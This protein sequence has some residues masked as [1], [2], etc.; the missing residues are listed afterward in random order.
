MV[1]E[2]SFVKFFLRKD[3]HIAK[4]RVDL[5]HI[6]STQLDSNTK[7]VLELSFV[8]FFL[9]KDFTLRRIASI[10][11]TSIAPNLVQTGE[12]CKG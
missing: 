10:K 2:L 12:W 8:Q 4:N 5:V 1:L 3:V 7:M 11:S 9:R 6:D